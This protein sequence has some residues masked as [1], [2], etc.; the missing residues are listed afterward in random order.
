MLFH[1]FHFLN[2][3]LLFLFMCIFSRSRVIFYRGC[4]MAVQLCGAPRWGGKVPD[5]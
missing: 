3:L 1:G 2:L 4:G 5:G